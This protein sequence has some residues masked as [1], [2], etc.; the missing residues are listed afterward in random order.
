MCRISKKI[1]TIVFTYNNQLT[2]ENKSISLVR[3]KT[4]E[5]YMHTPLSNI[6]VLLYLILLK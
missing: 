5:E 1:L 2:I 3:E 6:A 4:S